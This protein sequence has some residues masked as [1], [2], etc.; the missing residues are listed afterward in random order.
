MYV[1]K[2][3]AAR[4]EVKEFVIFMLSKSFTPA[5]QTGEVGYVPLSDLLY[6]AATKRVTAGTAG[7]LWPKGPETG[8]TLDRYLQ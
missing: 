8:A 2:D 1:R 5:I 3:A 4:P 6:E 7:T